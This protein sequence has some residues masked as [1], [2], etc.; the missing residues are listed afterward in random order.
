MFRRP[1]Y[2]LR[3]RL[4]AGLLLISIFAASAWAASSPGERASR[5]KNAWD[6]AVIDRALATAKPGQKW[7]PFGDVGI[8]PELLKIF[9]ERL[10]ADRARADSSTPGPEAVTPPNTTFK[11]PSGIV[12]YRFD[13]TQVS[14]GTITA[15]KMQQFRDSAAEWVAFAN[16]H[17]NEFTGTPPTNYVTV[18][19]D[20][21]LGGGGFSSS[22]GKAGGEQFI[23]IAPNSWN[24][25]TLCHEIG[26]TIGLFHEQQ[27][28][29]RDTFVVIHFDNIATGDQG[30]FVKILGGTTAIGAY[31]FFSIMH[32][33][34]RTQAVNPNLDTISMQPG[35]EQF[36]DIIGNVFYRTLSKLD[37]SGMAQ[38]YGNPTSLPGAVV[39]NTQDSG[40]GSLRAAV[41]FAFDKSTDVPS[42][43]TT[44]SFQIPM[45]DPGWDGNEFNIQPTALMTT[46]GAGTTID[47]STQTTF[48]G[49]TNPSGPEI[50][51]NGSQLTVQNLFA[52]GFLLLDPNCTLKNLVISGFNQQGLILDGAS[53]TGNLVK[54]CYIGT[55]AAGTSA[56][57]NTFP[58]IEIAEG[59]NGN[60]IGGT[61]AAARNVISGNAHYGVSI[62]DGGSDNNLVEGNY[63][64]LNAAGTAAIPN[65][66]D[67]VSIFLGA[68]TN[69]IGGTSG[70]ARNVISGNNSNGIVCADAGTD[71]NLI[72]GN[73]IGLDA[74]GSASVPNNFAGIGIFAGAKKN[75]V[76]S[77]SATGA[78][79]IISGNL[80]Q[81]VIIGDLGTNSNMV[82][83]NFIGT[84]VNGTAALANQFSGVAIFGSAASN[85]IGGSTAKARNIISGNSGGGVNISGAKTKANKV[86][87]NFIGTNVTASSALPNPVGV[88]IFDHATRNTIGGTKST[89]RNVISG[90]TFQGVTISNTGTKSNKVIGNFIGTD[91]TGNAALPNGGAGISIFNKAQLNVIGGPTAASR[92]VISGNL[93]QGITLSDTG[94]SSNEISSNFIGLKSTGNAALPNQFSGIDIFLGA[95]SNIIGGPGKGNVIS[96]NANYG[97]AISGAG[98]SLNRVQGNLIGLNAAGTSSIGNAFPGIVFF[99]AAQS[100]LI[101]DSAAGAGNVIAFNGF[102]GIQ[103]FDNTTLGNDFNAN[104][105]FSNGG[106]GIN[107][108]GGAENGSGVTANDTKDPDVG[109]NGLQNYPVLTSATSAAVIQGSLNSLPNKTYRIDFFSSPAADPSGFGEGQAFLGAVN[110]ATNNN[111]DATFNPDLPGTLAAGSVVTAT[112]TEI[113]TGAA[114]TSEFS[115]AILVP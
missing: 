52:P 54:G 85:V 81:G 40:P 16:L 14:N 63:I 105:M 103:V 91:S 24:R 20:P 6:I 112:A 111:G 84:D 87:G 65:T 62:H 88:Q 100:N 29:D 7:V 89:L 27:R 4:G 31:D 45:S 21:S 38:I 30:N 90:N 32:Y 33:S 23:K 73:Y 42:V 101:G 110:V 95:A 75:I 66:F 55:N 50:V 36:I 9:R 106:L 58:G 26:H 49:D 94:T 78:R 64:G 12:R 104:S 51:L 18:Q 53:A 115:A 1:V 22:V 99:N 48:T 93:N 28:D 97:M 77:K 19:E 44:V 10:V 102:G 47:G 70:G 74:N 92:N 57:A 2:P 37:R 60:T 76:G 46:P 8:K 56:L 72:Q 79:N 113:G 11:W 68:G 83:G 59:A 71:A 39:T 13:P 96:G 107:L 3:E 86:Q 82:Q 61:T 69:T 67:G 109:P 41:Y 98:T 5:A 34:R 108:V 35:F 43:P 17:F 25:G 15:A 80:A 114:G